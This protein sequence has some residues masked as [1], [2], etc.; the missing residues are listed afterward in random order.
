MH[1]VFVGPEMIIP[2]SV[3]KS[4]LYAGAEIGYY[5]VYAKAQDPADGDSAINSGKVAFG[6]NSEWLWPM[7]EKCSIGPAISYS[8]GSYSVA[9]AAVALRFAF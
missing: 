3:G 6:L 5:L 7:L 8:F 9:S 4:L 1:G 2:T